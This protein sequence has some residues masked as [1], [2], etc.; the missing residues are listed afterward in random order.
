[1]SGHD[2]GVDWWAIGVIM[3]EMLIG[4]TPFYNSNRNRMLKNIKQGS[5]VFPDKKRFKIDYS[6]ELEDLIRKLVTVNPADR[7]GHTNDA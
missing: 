2:K 4:T 1:M 7:I 6:D 3:Y 5:V